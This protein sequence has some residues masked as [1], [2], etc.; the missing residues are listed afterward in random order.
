MDETLFE[1]FLFTYVVYIVFHIVYS[2]SYLCPGERVKGTPQGHYGYHHYKLP[3]HYR[4]C[5]GS[6]FAMLLG[7]NCAHKD[8]T[9]CNYLHGWEQLMVPISKNGI[10]KAYLKMILYGEFTQKRNGL[11]HH[12]LTLISFRIYFFLLYTTKGKGRTFIWIFSV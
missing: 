10:N 3:Q 4:M 2:V 11:L 12:L 8:S 5:V 1:W 6:A 7:S 9:T